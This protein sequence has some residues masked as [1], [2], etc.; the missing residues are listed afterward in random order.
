MAG[1]AATSWADS[2]GLSDFSNNAESPAATSPAASV[3]VAA[4]PAAAAPTAAAVPVTAAAVSL[5]PSDPRFIVSVNF[6]GIILSILLSSL[7]P[8]IF[9]STDSYIRLITSYLLEYS[10][11]WQT[12]RCYINAGSIKVQKEILFNAA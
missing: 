1:V 5:A 8:S 7:I 12:E 6:P 9:S 10:E 11:D 2:A 4:A 3:A